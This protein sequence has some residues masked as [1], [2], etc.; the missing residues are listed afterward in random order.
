M[1]ALQKRLYRGAMRRSR[2]TILEVTESTPSK[3]AEGSEPVAKPR[4][5]GKVADGKGHT[6]N[7]A[8]VLMELRKAAL[9]PML[10]RSR[11]D[12]QVLTEMTKLLLKE[13]DFKKRG[14]VFQYVKEDMEVMTDAE[15]QAFCRTYKVRIVSKVKE[16]N[17]SL[18]QQ[19]TKRYLLDEDCYIDAGK[20][21][22]LLKL[23]GNYQK[24]RRKC[25]IFSQV[26]CFSTP[27]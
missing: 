2:K 5:T 9:H 8:N 21:K 19:S 27:P 20:V 16:P 7:S 23:L 25:L 17:Y 22:L 11:F 26:W 12:D 1:T 15:L 6:E 24:E 3:A 14:A 4:T 10:F 13:P 18:A